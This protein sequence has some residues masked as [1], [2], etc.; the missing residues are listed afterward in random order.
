M[1]SNVNSI[2]ILCGPPCGSRSRLTR[3]WRYLRSKTAWGR[4][5]VRPASCKKRQSSMRCRPC[6]NFF[7]VVLM[8]V[9]TTMV[10]SSTY[11]VDFS[12]PLQDNL[13]FRANL[14]ITWEINF[15]QSYRGHLRSRRGTAVSRL[16]GNIVSYPAHL[17]VHSFVNLPG[18]G[19]FE[20]KPKHLPVSLQR[21]FSLESR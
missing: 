18:C 14:R 9:S 6:P 8:A 12:R 5:A 13:C 16:Q 10:K 21:A 4:L 2:T 20:D 11:I 17:S 19:S 15:S 7:F 1:N 3:I